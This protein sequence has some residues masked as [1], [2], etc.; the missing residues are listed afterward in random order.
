VQ[1][2]AP[3]RPRVCAALCPQPLTAHTARERL[4]QHDLGAGAS[5][6]GNAF[7][8]ARTY[9]QITMYVD[10]PGEAQ[11]DACLSVPPETSSVPPCGHGGS[12]PNAFMVTPTAITHRLPPR[13]ASGTHV[14]LELRTRAL[15]AISFGTS[16]L[17][18]GSRP[19]LIS[20]DQLLE[21][22][23]KL[24]LSR[25]FRFAR[26]TCS[27]SEYY[28]PTSYTCSFI[29]PCSALRSRLRIPSPP[30]LARTLN[31]TPPHP[32]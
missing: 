23:R 31:F 7:R 17:R 14:K 8:S 27:A 10:G 12:L 15:Q 5:L 32:C 11:F 6:W 29:A 18:C 19:G 26:H 24:L 16:S 20:C 25:R 30:T 3:V 22:A 28:I 9:E 4:G 13:I 1:Q 2:S 21:Q